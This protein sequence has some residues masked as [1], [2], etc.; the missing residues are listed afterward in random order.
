MIIQMNKIEVNGY[1]VITGQ[2]IVDIVVKMI[3]LKQTY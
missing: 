3:S 2:V 1:G